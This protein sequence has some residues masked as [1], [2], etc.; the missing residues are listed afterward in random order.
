MRE[1]FELYATGKYTKIQVLEI[2]TE[3]DLRTKREQKLLPKHSMQCCV[4]P[5]TQAGC[6]RRGSERVKGLHEPVVSQE[7]FETVQRMLSGRRLVSM[8]KRK[9]NPA[10]PLKHFVKCGACGTPL[11]GGMKKVS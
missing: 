11:T 5:F 6:T 8:P 1:A 2:I 10:F 7:L 3:K 4:G 9:H